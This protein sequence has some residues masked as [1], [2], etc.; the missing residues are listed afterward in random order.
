MKLK[1]E[2]WLNL[3]VIEDDFHHHRRMKMMRK[4]MSSA[5]AAAADVLQR[6]LERERAG[7]ADDDGEVS[8]VS[9][10]LDHS[11]RKDSYPGGGAEEHY[12][13]RHQIQVPFQRYPI[14]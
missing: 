14:C 10:V 1:L 6:P 9:W 3:E 7:A 4:T 13:R 5:V 2:F 11:F 8:K 12:E